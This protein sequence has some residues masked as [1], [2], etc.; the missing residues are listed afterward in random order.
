MNA[1]SW[2]ELA[3]E[4]TAF[5]APV[6]SAWLADSP[7]WW[8]ERS[9]G[10]IGGWLGGGVG[11]LGGVFG[12][13]V[14]YC[15]TRGKARSAVLSVQLAAIGLGLSLMLAALVALMLGQPFHVW[16][17]LGLPGLITALVMAPLYPVVKARYQEAEQRKLAAAEL[18][19]G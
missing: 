3:N 15:A 8:D 10:L 1:S 4:L 16:F 12:S 5:A 18:R 7:A 19:R 13:L 2:I 11:I 6:R 14:G 17:P 9:A